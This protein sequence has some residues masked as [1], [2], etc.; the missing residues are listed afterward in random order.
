MDQRPRRWP[1]AAGEQLHLAT[2]PVVWAEALYFP[3]V[4]RLARDIAECPA[5]ARGPRL[6]R[7]CLVA[8]LHGLPDY[9]MA[10]IARTAAGVNA[11][12]S[13]GIQDAVTQWDAAATSPRVAVTVDLTPDQLRSLQTSQSTTGLKPTQ[14]IRRL[15]QQW[16][17][18]QDR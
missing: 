14:Q 18:S 17:A 13:Q 4:D 8:L 1:Y 5:P 11:A 10:L 12:D 15:V 3:T 7:A 6:A 2:G 9:A 16:I